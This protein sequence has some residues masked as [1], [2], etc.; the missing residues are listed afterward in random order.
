MASADNDVEEEY[1]EIEEIEEYEET[2]DEQEAVKTTQNKKCWVACA[3]PRIGR[4]EAWV[5]MLSAKGPVEKV[6]YHDRRKPTGD[7]HYAEVLFRSAEEA[8]SFASA[9]LQ[10]GGRVL[11]SAVSSTGAREVM[12]EGLELPPAEI[13]RQ[14]ESL[15]PLI[16]SSVPTRK[17]SAHLVYATEAAADSACALNG[18]RFQGGTV[19]VSKL[20]EPET[21]VR[22]DLGVSYPD[23]DQEDGTEQKHVEPTKKRRR[24]DASLAPSR[25][26]VFHVLEPADKDKVKKLRA[27]K[28]TVNKNKQVVE[29]ALRKRKF[30]IGTGASEA[31]L[32]NELS[33]LRAKQRKVH[34]ALRKI[35]RPA[36]ARVQAEWAEG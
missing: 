25:P 36:R 12:V 2:D 33:R 11:T 35:T 29:D 8:S 31:D 34:V 9:P 19:R 30:E 17:L 15:G 6:C 32:S 1:E 18:R 20:P 28:E 13:R 23:E 27:T 3:L 21:S 5:E 22:K 14:F 16:A 26:D 10:E 4:A 24:V 7:I